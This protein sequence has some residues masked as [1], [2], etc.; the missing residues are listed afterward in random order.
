MITQEYKANN[1][2]LTTLFL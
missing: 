2:Q 1:H